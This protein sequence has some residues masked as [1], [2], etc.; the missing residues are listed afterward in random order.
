VDAEPTAAEP[1]AA[2]PTAAGPVTAEPVTAEPVTAEASRQ[3]RRALLTQHWL[4]LTFLHW[5]V[6]PGTVAPLLPAGT[7]PDQF[8]GTSYVG[9]IAFRMHRVGWLGMPGLPYLG[10][11]P[12][13]NIRL[14][15][16][17]SDGRRGVVFRSLEAAR[18]VPVLVARWGF[19]LPYTWA[20]MTVDRSGDTLT[21][22]SQRRWP[23]PRWAASRLTIRVGEQVSQPTDLEHFM[24]A[25]WGLHAAWHGGRT[26]FIPN[27]HPR[28]SLYR[29]RLLDLDENLVRAAGLPA[30]AGDPASV[31]YSPGVPVRFGAPG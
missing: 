25:R 11:F 18:L 1:T 20:R 28:W 23:R 8:G 10:S 13:T 24:T 4:D 12:E 30:P 2:E 14:Y 21:Y 31:L 7:R 5:A 6:D 16:V 9:L 19:R 29:A 15:S 27:E 3:V 22:T 17:G 26:I